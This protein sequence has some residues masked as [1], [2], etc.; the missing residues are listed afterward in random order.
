MS[1]IYSVLQDRSVKIGLF[2]SPTGTGKSLSLICSVLSFYLDPNIQPAGGGQEAEVV[3][4]AWEQLFAAKS[5]ATE[6]APK[7]AVPPAG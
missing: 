5:E 7:T 6:K 2:S 3:D 4:D 1:K